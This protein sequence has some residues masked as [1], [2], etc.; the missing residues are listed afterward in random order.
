M[1]NGNTAQQEI[2]DLM[3]FSTKANGRVWGYDTASPI[4]FVQITLP[5]FKSFSMQSHLFRVAVAHVMIFGY[6]RVYADTR[7]G[8]AV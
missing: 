6:R 5:H 1:V 3:F 8:D 2:I 7:L 4:I